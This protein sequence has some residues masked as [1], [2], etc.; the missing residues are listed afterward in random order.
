MNFLTT[1]VRLRKTIER[2]MKE[3][4]EVPGDYAA[5]DENAAREFAEQRALN[6]LAKDIRYGIRAAMLFKQIAI[7]EGYMSAD[8]CGSYFMTISPKTDVIDFHS[9]KKLATKF[10]QRK[11]FLEYTASYEQRGR[12]EETLGDGFHLHIVCKTSM[13]SKSELLR[14][15][16]STFKHCTDDQCIDV[17]YCKNP[18]EVTQKYLIDYESKDE[19]KIGLKE[20]DDKW[21]EREGLASLYEYHPKRDIEDEDG[22]LIKSVSGPS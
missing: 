7:E 2:S 17:K 6:D 18:S 10:L 5:F 20:W 21:R 14:A 12:S 8:N 1:G 19:H 3:L 22:P 15:A 4:T 16:K 9:F 11:C 13:S